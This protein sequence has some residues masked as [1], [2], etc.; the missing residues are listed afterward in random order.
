MKAPHN[1]GFTL[2]ELLIVVAIIGVLSAI[3]LPGLVRARIS[4]NEASTIG[5]LR[6]VNSA[7]QT[8]AWSC[9]QGR[10]AGTLEDLHRGTA[11][12]AEGFISSD[13]A[14]SNVAKS[15]YRVNV[16]GGSPA[17]AGVTGCNNALSLTETYYA[18]AVP[19]T[20][21]LTGHRWFGTNQGGAIFQST[22]G[23]LAATQVG[24]VAGGTPIQ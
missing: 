9:G 18:S 20:A 17:P 14:T 10:Y 1:S 12:R 7:E 2:I 6:A 13:L 21:N 5:S 15:G 8:Y 19:L 4:G 11:A 16:E 3:A 23:A 24:P 22:T